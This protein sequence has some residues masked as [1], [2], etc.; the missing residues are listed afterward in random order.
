MQTHDSL[1]ADD[2]CVDVNSEVDLDAISS[3]DQHAG[4][5]TVE[6]K[7]EGLKRELAREKRP[8]PGHRTIPAGSK[9]DDD[10]LI[11]AIDTIATA[12]LIREGKSKSLLIEPARAALIDGAR[13]LGIAPLRKAAPTVSDLID[14][15]S[16]LGSVVYASLPMHQRV[17]SRKTLVGALQLLLEGTVLPET[18]RLDAIADAT[19]WSSICDAILEPM[20]G[21]K[22]KRT[23]KMLSTIAERATALI[24]GSKLTQAFAVALAEAM[25]AASISIDDL[26]AVSGLSYTTI[27]H[28][29]HGAHP[30][31]DTVEPVKKIEQILGLAPGVLVSLIDAPATRLVSDD[32]LTPEVRQRLEQASVPMT[33]L[34]TDWSQRD[35]ADKVQIIKWIDDHI[36]NGSPYRRYLRQGANSENRIEHEALPDYLAAELAS[37]VAFKTAEHDDP[38]SPREKREFRNGRNVT[39]GGAWREK[40]TVPLVTSM[41]GR[42]LTMLRLRGFT[43][44]ALGAGFLVH[45]N[46]QW[47]LCQDI[48]RRRFHLL[49]EAGAFTDMGIEEPKDGMV[50]TQGD[51][52]RCVILSGLFNP[53]T[54]YFFRNR[55][56]LNVLLQVKLPT[57]VPSGSNPIKTISSIKIG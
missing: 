48:A 17:R 1:F 32:V 45:S 29:L 22:R 50:F 36:L 38:F 10:A 37:A 35:R 52:N 21:E 8:L 30:R 55:P 23:G 49:H 18:T 33:F 51:A 3:L 7:I 47:I 25:K 56:T 12:S 2:D 16:N 24:Q 19:A 53:E 39:I 54:G 57:T 15:I 34:P 43:T 40:T 5:V 31:K 9:L 42:L 14:D 44:S 46:T 13:S 26:S 6:I 41:I 20:S 27:R 28:W 4:R 11:E